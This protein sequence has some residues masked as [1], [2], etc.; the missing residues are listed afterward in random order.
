MEFNNLV[1][2]IEQTYDVKLPTE[3]VKRNAPALTYLKLVRVL[4]FLRIHTTGLSAEAIFADAVREEASQCQ[5]RISPTTNPRTQL[6]F[7]LADLHEI[8]ENLI[9]LSGVKERT[10]SFDS[11]MWADDINS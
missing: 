2:Y 9:T 1:D 3:F 10:K 11:G 4:R 5:S 6:M 8:I 7:E